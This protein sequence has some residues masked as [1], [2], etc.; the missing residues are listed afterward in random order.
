MPVIGKR[1][2]GRPTEPVG[3]RVYQSL[4][5]LIVTHAFEDQQRF[6]TEHELCDKLS[7]SR[8]TLRAALHKIEQEGLL[9]RRAGDGAYLAPKGLN[10]L[11]EMHDAAKEAPLGSV[12]QKETLPLRLD[13]F[14]YPDANRELWNS[15]F[16]EFCR[17]QPELSVEAEKTTCFAVATMNSTA[18]MPD[19][20]NI[21][22]ADIRTL[23]SQQLLLD[24]SA[25]KDD[26]RAVGFAPEALA[27]C[28]VDGRLYAVPQEINLPAIYANTELLEKLGIEIDDSTWTWDD[29][30]AI[31]RLGVG[32]L[33]AQ[34]CGISFP[35]AYN[36]LVSFGVFRCDQPF[37]AAAY[38]RNAERVM[39]LLNW[40]HEATTLNNLLFDPLAPHGASLN[41]FIA[42]QMLFCFHGSNLNSHFRTFCHFPVKALQPP[43]GAGY[44]PVK[45]MVAW[46]ASAATSLPLRSVEWLKFV[47]G[48][49]GMAAIASKEGNIPGRLL[50][51]TTS[52]FSSRVLES[53]MAS[54]VFHRLPSSTQRILEFEVWRPA[55]H[56]FFKGEITASET[57]EMLKANHEKVESIYK[58][59]Q[60]MF[61]GQHE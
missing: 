9:I 1:R 58:D 37:L 55:F 3:D 33:G 52:L 24:L 41:K 30:L 45:I 56:R 53:Q 19:V 2:S 31:M 14:E 29:V 50:P 8:G 47:S 39:R 26:V 27:E 57:V 49:K 32:K 36:Y 28:T 23:A 12:Q 59:R 25:F 42:G 22:S 54:G 17:C 21:N 35:A 38:S 48:D 18:A 61:G 46:A 40:L 11:R 13:S 7:V 51:G 60:I 43:L 15:L 44:V 10:G 20:F 6:P 16:S 34:I 5:S 4:K